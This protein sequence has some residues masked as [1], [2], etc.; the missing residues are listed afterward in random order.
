MEDLEDTPFTIAIRS[1]LVR[2]APESLLSGG[3]PLQPRDEGKRGNHRTGI[4]DCNGCNQLPSPLPSVEARRQQHKPE[5]HNY[6]ND[7]QG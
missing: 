7:Q 2:V 4:T 5:G 6:L 3:S 1:M